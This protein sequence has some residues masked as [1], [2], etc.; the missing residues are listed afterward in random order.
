MHHKA[1][2]ILLLLGV[3][4]NPLFFARADEVYKADNTVNNVR[5]RNEQNPTAQD[6]S[7]RKSSI[8]TTAKL[9]RKIMRTAGL[10]TD[11]QNVKLIDENGCV[12]LRGPV[13]SEREKTV[14]DD[15]ARECCGEH[16]KN[17]LEVK[18]P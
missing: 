6:Q 17:E 8:R 9:R 1:I 7:N 2:A 15:L 11:A 3:N 18:T 5:D 13:D 14:L 10:S 16:F 12:F 4:L